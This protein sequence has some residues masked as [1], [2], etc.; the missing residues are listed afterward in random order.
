M[1]NKQDITKKVVYREKVPE[2]QKTKAWH[3]AKAEEID[4]GS[5]F[6]ESYY[7]DKVNYDL[8][9][10]IL[11]Q[12]DFEYVTKPYGITP[13][14]YLPEE[15]QNFP[16]ITAN[17]K[18]LE[19][20][21]LKRPNNMRVFSI[22]PEAINERNKVL[23]ELNSKYIID[24]IK[25]ARLEMAMQSNPNM[26][27]EEMMQLEQ[28]IM[29]PQEIQKY[30]R[31]YRDSY[32][33]MVSEIFNELKEK[34][35]LKEVWRTTFK[36]GMTT[37]KEIYHTWIENGT[38][39]Q[40]AVNPLRFDCDLDPDLNFIHEAEWCRTV[41]YMSPSRVISMYGDDLTNAEQK[42]IYE[43]YG[44]YGVRKR[45]DDKWEIEGDLY[46]F[47][48][49][50][51]WFEQDLEN[52][53]QTGSNFVEVRHYTWRSW[54][55]EGILT[56]MDQDGEIQQMRVPENYKLNEGN[57]D[58]VIDWEWLPEI[59]EITRIND[60][61]WVKYGP[62]E[63]F[64]ENPED[65][66]DCP[67][68]YTGVIHNNLNSRAIAPVGLMKP[69]QYMYNI[70]YRQIQ[71]DLRSDKGRKLVANINQIPTSSGIDLAKWQHY[72]EN[73]D[74]I[75]VDPNEEG[76]RGNIDLSSWRNIDMT[77]AQSIDKK[78]Q[79]LEYI[80]Q[81]CAKVIGMND[82]RLGQQGSRELVGTTQQQI[83]QSNYATEPWFATHELGKKIA[84]EMLLNVAK[85]A[86]NKYGKKGVVYVGSDLSKRVLELDKDKIKLAQVGVFVSSSSDDLRMYE[87]LKQIAH[88]AV[89]TQAATLSSIAKLIRGNATPGELIATL[90][91][92]ENRVMQIQAQQGQAEREAQKAM[93]DARAQ[94]EQMKLE[95]D[96][97]KAD[98]DSFTKIR[99]AEIG[100]FRFT[101]EQDSDGNGVPDQLELE[102]F[103]AD[104]TAK[105]EELKLKAQEMQS[106]LDLERQKLEQKDRE[107]ESKERI[108]KLK[109]RTALK[110]KTSGEK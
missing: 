90:E 97:Y 80:D 106:K 61:I 64:Y 107:I 96:K 60:D 67:Q 12:S 94:L 92:G 49:G 65:P 84:T 53:F 69:F 58:I 68:P 11:N 33:T 43:N 4:R 100:S 59:R 89:Q 91:E 21:M 81:Q 41:D 6:D 42:R 104:V 86:Y 34:L 98:L 103:K 7:A 37:G 20:E 35:M 110:N 13:R 51:Q 70:V 82:A 26:N 108:E 29:T 75:W 10:G 72:L 101:E 24:M 74:I 105:N 50:T 28:E 30:I 76:N 47:Q 99:V 3:I 66:Y 46:D 16:I 79:L 45:L 22:N 77:A 1:E 19:G 56:Y 17:F 102:K 88:A 38:P 15:M 39:K 95:L 87:E 40:K 32:E 109:A 23:G 78:I 83:V 18:Y 5:N 31:N 2:S 55:K 63:K 52:D 14:A 54:Y 62:I 25:K 71:G 85:Y 9:N 36:H 27:Q 57:G 44:K 8:V 48:D 93:E 73:D